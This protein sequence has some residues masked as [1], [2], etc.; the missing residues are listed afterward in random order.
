MLTAFRATT[1]TLV[2]FL[3]ARL[4]SDIVLGP[5][6]NA[7]LG[8]AMRVMP[9]TPSEMAGH[10][11]GLSIWL[12]RIVRDEDRLN[13]PPRRIS[14]SETDHRPLPMRLHFLAT[15]ITDSAA[16][17]GPM[18][19]QVILGKVLQVFHD[20]PQIAGTDL[21]DDYSGTTVQLNVR[22]ES[23][24]LEELTRVWEAL[25]TSYQTSVSYEVTGVDIDSA[26][27]P[28]Q[29]RPVELPV[30]QQAIIV[31]GDA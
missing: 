26:L 23:L 19:E 31:G 12:Y 4:E 6:F 29:T 22:L 28:S 15:P 10:H 30:I 3:Q 25:Q 16:T 17:T 2:E 27:Q 18:T 9:M 21:A 14:R 5:S 8:G 24:T 20:T 1:N 11:E 13:L 7:G